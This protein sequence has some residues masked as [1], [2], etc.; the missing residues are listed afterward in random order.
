MQSRSGGD[1]EVSVSRAALLQLRVPGPGVAGARGGV[2]ARKVET[3]V[4]DVWRDGG[5][6]EGVLVPGCPL[7]LSRVPAAG[8]ACPQG[9]VL[10]HSAGWCVEGP[11]K[12]GVDCS[13]CPVCYS[14]GS[15]S[16]YL[17]VV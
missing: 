4:L 12:K 17:T 16:D 3:G 13:I 11:E 1:E 6:A 9:G 14:D 5:Q 10:F 8:V 7:L 2:H 15:F